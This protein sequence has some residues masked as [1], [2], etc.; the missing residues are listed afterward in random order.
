MEALFILDEAT[1]GGVPRCVLDAF[2]PKQTSFRRVNTTCGILRA[3][4]R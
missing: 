4:H 1:G 3:D 2:Y